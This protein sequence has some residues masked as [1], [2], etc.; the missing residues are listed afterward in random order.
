[1]LIDDNED[2]TDLLGHQFR[3]AGYK[4]VVAGSGEE[5]LELFRSKC[6]PDFILLDVQLPDMSGPDLLDQ[7]QED[8]PFILEK[9]PVMFYTAGLPP[10]DGRASGCLS[11]MSDATQIIAEVK[12]CVPLDK[13]VPAFL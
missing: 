11:K 3:R 12:K 10:D 9:T 4:V 6:L 13:K 8:F 7:L 1:M 5:A 2:I